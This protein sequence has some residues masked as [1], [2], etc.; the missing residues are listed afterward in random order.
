LSKNRQFFAKYFSEKI[1][2]IITSV[3]DWANFRLLGDWALVLKILEISSNFW[4]IFS[5]VKNMH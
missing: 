1:L 5:M 3:P 4:V 2:K